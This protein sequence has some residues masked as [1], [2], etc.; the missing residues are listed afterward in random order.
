MNRFQPLY[1]LAAVF[2][3]LLCA[4]PAALACSCM[5]G[6]P[7][8]E[9]F[10]S[11]QA[12]FI[13]KVVGAKEQRQEK[14]EDGTTTTFQVGEIYFNV[15][16]SFLGVKGTRVVIHSGTGGGDCGYWFLKGKRYLVYANGKSMETL[17]TNICMRTRPLENA[18]EDLSFLRTMPR[19]GAGVRIYGTV[20]IALKDPKSAD[21]R[22]STPLSGIT[23]KI[24]GNRTFDAVTDAEGRYELSGLQAGKYKVYAEVPD[25]Y[26]RGAYWVREIEIADRGCSQENFIAENDSKITGRVLKPD[27]TGLA[28]AKVELIPVDAEDASVGRFGLDQDYAN[29]EGEFKLVQVAP[30]RYLLGVNITSSPDKESPFPRT[31]YPGTT[32]RSKAVVLEIGLGQKLP[33]LDIHLPDSLP[34]FVVRGFV[35]WPDGNLAA[36]VDVYI[37]DVNYPGWCV[38]GCSQ[39]TDAQGQFELRGYSGRNYRV[40]S[41]AERNAD[42]NKREDVYGVSNPFLITGGVDGLKI[43]LS[44][45]GRP[46]DDEKKEADPAKPLQ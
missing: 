30:G 31:F 5:K 14:N 12:V 37:E 27:G 2:V 20:T 17:E 43:V 28:K 8:C 41:T 6:E 23:V 21:W 13:G 19:K 22:T 11:A 15:E 35:I 44:R 29:E 16:Q 7:T 40:V 25:F 24:A 18:D 36:G 26:Y 4:P 32:D 46:W 9:A 45:S 1:L 10:G 33:N 3:L 38:N 42:K 39:K 34:E